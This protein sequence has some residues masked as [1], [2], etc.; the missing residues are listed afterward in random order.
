MKNE[1]ASAAH[2]RWLGEAKQFHG[3]FDRAAE[4]VETLK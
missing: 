3:Q 4:L 2:Y 1:A